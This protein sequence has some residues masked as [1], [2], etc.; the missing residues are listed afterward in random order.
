VIARLSLSL[1]A[2]LTFGYFL[3][4]SI[5]PVQRPSSAGVFLKAS[6]AIGFG[7]GV[8]S[9]LYFLVLLFVGTSQTALILFEAVSIFV[10]LLLTYGKRAENNHICA[11]THEKPALQTRYEK[12]L[13]IAFYSVL[14]CASANFILIALRL[15]GGG[16]DAWAIWNLHARFIFRGGEHWTDVFSS[17]L[18][19]STHPDYPF[20]V[21][22]TVARIWK[23]LGHETQLVPVIVGMVF[24]FATAGLIYS[25]LTIL[26][27]KSQGLLAGLFLFSNLSFIILGTYQYADVPMGFFFLGS[28]VLILMQERFPENYG[29]SFLAGAT[30]G[31]AGWTKNEGLLFLVS[32]FISRLM[33]IF[34]SHDRNIHKK[35]LL[36]FILGSI[37]ALEIIAYFKVNFAPQSDLLQGQGFAQVIDKLG[38]VSR[39]VQI[40]KASLAVIIPVLPQVILLLVYPLCL[41]INRDD[42]NR[43]NVAT[44]VITM[45]FM[46]CGYIL[47]YVITP[48]ELSWHLETSQSRLLLQLW[49]SILLTFFMIV[50][51]PEEALIDSQIEMGSK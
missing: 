26:R 14:V 2:P 49:P 10:L 32:L 30:A 45:F 37:P 29:L 4:R 28:F 1:I 41:G 34:L 35:Q 11:K 6:L 27:S 22:L 48:Y 36:S 19:P 33:V 42:K 44:L 18:S 8:T 3:L 25:A 5:L 43:I 31:F 50:R 21:P 46:A 15:P 47:I 12:M 51:T 39:Y 9:C 24:I 7:F 17:L 20:L 40:L 13:S 16:W 38:Q 23:Y